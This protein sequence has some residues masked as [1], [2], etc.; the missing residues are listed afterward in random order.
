M[1]NILSDKITLPKAFNPVA[2][3]HEIRDNYKKR[4]LELNI[5]QEELARRS[6]VSLGSIK[7]FET[8]A[9]ISLKH[10]LRLAVV[11]N[12][13][14]AFHDLFSRKQFQSIEEVVSASQV[15]KRKRASA[16]D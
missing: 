11:L 7:R 16:N 9:E 15:N 1:N 14:E 13:T 12:S 4:R 3:A 8:K 5:T 10:L 6:A 2:I